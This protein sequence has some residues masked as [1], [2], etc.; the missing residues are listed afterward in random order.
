MSQAGLRNRSSSWLGLSATL[1]AWCY[2]HDVAAADLRV[3]SGTLANAASGVGGMAGIGSGVPSLGW[4]GLLQALLGLVLVIGLVFACAWLARRFGLQQPRGT[5]LVKVVGGTALSNKER[6][7]VVEVADTWL[8]LGVGSGQV[9]TLHTLPAGS[10]GSTGSGS[11]PPSSVN[12]SLSAS[13]A[14]NLRDKLG[15]SRP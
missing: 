1:A 8:V 9:R 5:G 11:T 2:A 12:P 14:Q 4:G 13:F 6:V 3:A 15:K 7:V 10:A